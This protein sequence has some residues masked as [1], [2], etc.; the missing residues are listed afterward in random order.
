MGTFSSLR[1]GFVLA[2]KVTAAD[3]HARDSARLLLA[4][5]GGF[6]QKLP[7]IWVDS[8]YSRLLQTW[9]EQGFR[10]RLL[11]ILP[12]RDQKGFSLVARHWLAKRT[13]ACLGLNRHL[14]KDYERLAESSVA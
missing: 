1:R 13:F 3:L 12:P 14:S 6:G 8:A 4:R 5:G 7:L 10:I 9:A 11:L 2:G